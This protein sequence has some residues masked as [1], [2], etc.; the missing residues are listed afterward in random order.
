MSRSRCSSATDPPSS[1]S[2]SPRF[3][4]R[5]TRRQRQDVVLAAPPVQQRG[6]ENR[7]G[8]ERRRCVS[9]WDCIDAIK[10]LL[11]EAT[12]A[13]MAGGTGERGPP[14]G[15]AHRAA[16]AP[17]G[18]PAEVARGPFPP[19]RGGTRRAARSCRQEEAAAPPPGVSAMLRPRGGGETSRKKRRRRAAPSHSRRTGAWPR[20]RPL[21]TRS[22]PCEAAPT[23]EPRLRPRQTRSCPSLRQR[24]TRSWPRSW[25][26][27]RGLGRIHGRRGRDRGRVHGRRGRG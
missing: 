14:A 20:R 18:M 16:E 1:R 9:L 7:R 27:G 3:D 11:F 10:G 6:P 19:P 8:R 26:R 5:H 22:R 24:Q 17:A 12:A 21:G 15:L 23:A 13:A 4:V 25:P 2:R